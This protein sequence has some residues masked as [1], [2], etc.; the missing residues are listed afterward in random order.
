MF[1]SVVTIFELQRG[2]LLVGRRDPIAAAPL[3]AWIEGVLAKTFEGR[4][5]PVDAVIAR[6][7]AALS[8]PDPSPFRDSLI[9][10]TALVHG[11][12]VVTRN[13]ADFAS[14]GCA[15]LNPWALGQ[16]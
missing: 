8:V 12:T 3:H 10:A 4:V 9:A 15:I 5:L 11:M 2:A 6:K 14:T 13:V 16:S 7:S 1:L